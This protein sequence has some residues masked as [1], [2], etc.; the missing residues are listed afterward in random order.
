MDEKEI[1]IIF[2]DPIAREGPVGCLD[3]RFYSFGSFT[4]FPPHGP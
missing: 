1:P 2:V 4:F 3:G